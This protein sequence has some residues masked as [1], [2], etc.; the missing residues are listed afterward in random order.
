MSKIKKQSTTFTYIFLAIY[1]AVIITWSC[2]PLS[3]KLIDTAAGETFA[4]DDVRIYQ[5]Y[6]VVTW[7]PKGV[8]K[9][10]IYELYYLYHF[11]CLIL[12][13]GHYTA[14]NMIFFFFMYYTAAHFELLLSCI[15]DIDNTFPERNISVTNICSQSMRSVNL[16][17]KCNLTS[18]LKD[19]SEEYKITSDQN[20]GSTTTG[21]KNEIPSTE[22]NRIIEHLRNCIKYHQAILEFSKEMNEFLSP[23]FLVYF[24]TSEFMMCLSV[25]QMNVNEGN[26]L[27]K[28]VMGVINV[29]SWPLFISWCGDY[30]IAKSN[31]IEKAVYGCRWYNRS[32]RFK[33][34]LLIKLMRAQHPVQ[35][36]A[37][38]FFPVSLE[39]FSEILNKVYA[40]FT[41]VKR[42]YES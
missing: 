13:I 37:G 29:C 8:S 6:P 33:K 16:L 36:S 4:E 22:E 11:S 34:L 14:C 10:P 9:P 20:D 15:E 31:A 7:L 30:L 18:Y 35:C 2:L 27:V 25:F 24:L 42:M 1:I 40:Y 32:E 3:K 41:I 39:S 12:V 26:G 19:N 28:F 38:K 5:Y 23:L 21:D 17:N